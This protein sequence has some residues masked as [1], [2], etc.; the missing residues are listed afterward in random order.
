MFSF[1]P[2]DLA[3]DWD[4]LVAYH[5]D[6]F[7]LSYGSDEAFSELAYRKIMRDRLESFPQG[8]RMVLDD[9]VVAGQVELAIREAQGRRFG[10]V[11]LFYLEPAWRGRGLGRELT[12]FAQTCFAAHGLDEYRLR[13]SAMNERAVRFYER[14]GFA[15]LGSEQ[16][17]QLVWIMRKSLPSRP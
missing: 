16:R 12:Q 10:Y 14:Q 3:G 4:K 2:I 9:A 15:R 17:G 8:Q 11:S 13:V 6:T 7:R 5:R 1:R